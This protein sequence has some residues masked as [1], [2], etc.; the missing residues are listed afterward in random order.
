MSER[1]RTGLIIIGV[2]VA[3][4]LYLLFVSYRVEALDNNINDDN[5]SYAVVDMLSNN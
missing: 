2:Y 1:V 4:I 5:T 3:F